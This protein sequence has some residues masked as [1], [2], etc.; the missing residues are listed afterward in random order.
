M[1]TA[2]I[3]LFNVFRQPSMTPSLQEFIVIIL[4]FY[5]I[6]AA[7][8]TV[9]EFPVHTAHMGKTCPGLARKPNRR[10][11]NLFLP[12]LHESESEAAC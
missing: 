11:A 6:L 8:L 5:Q 12:P 10:K 1:D 7:L 3:R 2:L 9:V 4:H